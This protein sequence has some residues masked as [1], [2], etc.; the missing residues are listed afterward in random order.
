MS[1]H[2]Y[3][4]IVCCCCMRDASNGIRVGNGC[5][6]ATYHYCSIECRDASLTDLLND[7]HFGGVVR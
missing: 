7:N 3:C 5:V 1:Y 4:D 2:L 6:G